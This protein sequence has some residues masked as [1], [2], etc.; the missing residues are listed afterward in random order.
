MQI[1]SQRRCLRE[2]ACWWTKKTSWCA[3]ASLTEQEFCN[4]LSRDPHKL[5][6]A[7]K[8]AEKERFP[9]YWPIIGSMIE[10]L[11]HTRTAPASLSF[12]NLSF[13]IILASFVLLQEQISEA[14]WACRTHWATMAFSASP[15]TDVAKV[16][17]RVATLLLSHSPT[18]ATSILPLPHLPLTI[19]HHPP[20]LTLPQLSICTFTQPLLAPTTFPFFFIW[21]IFHRTSASLWTI[22]KRG[23]VGHL[24]VS[25]YHSWISSPSPLF[26]PRF[27]LGKLR[28]PT[29]LSIGVHMTML[30]S[31]TA[32]NNEA[33]VKYEVAD[34]GRREG[35][36]TLADVLSGR[37][38]QL[39][40]CT[41]R[42]LQKRINQTLLLQGIS[43]FL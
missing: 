12:L 26:L 10:I 15:A 37:I 7:Q 1:N 8:A 9:I 40:P 43:L 13:G 6:R 27:Y 36:P 2:H 39:D 38:V 22:I 16:S 29:S 20:S 4:F 28:V 30:C 41:E 24:I 11:L 19:Y 42:Q 21:F 17:Y 34:T 5:R 23:W 14:Q 33:E 18:A 3:L 31:Q 32:M 35:A 25:S